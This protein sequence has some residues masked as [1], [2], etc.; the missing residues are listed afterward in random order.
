M[1]TTMASPDHMSARV[2]VVPL[3]RT[4]SPASTL[5]VSAI[6]SPIAPRRTANT[7]SC[8]SQARQTAPTDFVVTSAKRFGSARI[9][10]SEGQLLPCSVALVEVALLEQVVVEVVLLD[11]EVQL[12]ER[13][14]D[15][16]SRVPLR[17]RIVGEGEEH[18]LRGRLRE[19]GLVGVL[20]HEPDEP[21][22][23]RQPPLRV[24]KVELRRA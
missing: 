23:V 7:V 3:R 22:V 18:E 16:R 19:L 17:P 1:N 11:V 4:L 6:T 20:G 8:R 21:R 10:P 15:L 14:R 2:N 24:A 9:T 5:F 12:D 13:L